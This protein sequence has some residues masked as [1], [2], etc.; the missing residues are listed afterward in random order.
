M[1][2]EGAGAATLGGVDTPAVDRVV[3]AGVALV[4]GRGEMLAEVVVRVA[5]HVL[6]EGL[7]E[8]EHRRRALVHR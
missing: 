6:V 3:E 1:L 8:L 4:R 5:M 2:E 7:R